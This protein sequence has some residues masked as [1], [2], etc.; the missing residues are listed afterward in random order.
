MDEDTAADDETSVLLKAA[1]TEIE[2]MQA[3]IDI[4]AEDARKANARSDRAV[5]DV[6]AVLRQIEIESERLF[7]EINLQTNQQPGVLQQTL[8]ANQTV[9]TARTDDNQTVGLA[10]TDDNQTVRLA[11]TY[12]SQTVA[13]LAQTD[14]N[15]LGAYIDLNQNPVDSCPVTAPPTPGGGDH[16][17]PTA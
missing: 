16:G 15:S 3:T 6:N 9:G 4:T 17:T 11:Q 7:S 1:R 12:D 2:D 14:D 8:D 13:G 5:K 10:H